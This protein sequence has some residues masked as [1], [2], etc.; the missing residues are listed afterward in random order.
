VGTTEVH[1]SHR[2]KLTLSLKT[3]KLLCRQKHEECEKGRVP[4]EDPGNVLAS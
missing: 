4:E 3:T 1:T 2:G